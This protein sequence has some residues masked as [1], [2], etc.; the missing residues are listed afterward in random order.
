MDD[1]D[2]VR[3]LVVD[4]VSAS[5]TSP[6]WAHPSADLERI[7]GELRRIRDAGDVE[8]S[9]IE[10]NGRRVDAHLSFGDREWWIALALSPDELLVE[11]ASAFERPRPFAG[12]EGGIV[13]VLNGP[14]SSGKSSVMRAIVEL[15]S[16][17]WVAFDE[18]WF[19][20]VAMPYLIWPD[21]APSLRA[22]FLAGI[23]A[24]GSHGNQIVMTSGGLP[25]AEVASAF[26][27]TRLVAVGFDCPTGV[28]LSRQSERTDRWGGLVED[29]LG[30]HDG[31]RYDLRLD[32]SSLSPADLAQRI[33]D[34][35]RGSDTKKA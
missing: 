35:V 26:E 7:D 34:E 15:A 1:L 4:M 30:A 13:V 19:G 3:Q 8:A 29:S 11:R 32:S 2:D 16:E 14:S 21:A 5:Q 22:G 25:Y 6:T 10:V 24:L 33:I 27:R 28:L 9:S 18:L 20:A 23:A 31:W 17:P 12:I